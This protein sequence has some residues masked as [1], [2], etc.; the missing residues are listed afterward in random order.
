[1]LFNTSITTLF[2]CFILASCATK[3]TPT[4]WQ[5]A[6]GKPTEE[7]LLVMDVELTSAAGLLEQG[8]ECHLHARYHDGRDV[9]FA[10]KPGNRRSFWSAPAG[11]YEM[12][13]LSCGLFS[14]FNLPDYPAFTVKRGESYY[15]GM[16]KLHVASKDSLTW[17]FADL[18][19]DRLLTQFI[20]LPEAIKHRV[21]S[22][23][24]ERLI[25]EALIKKTPSGPS[26]RQLAPSS[27]QLSANDWPFTQCFAREQKINPLKAGLWAMKVSVE[28][29]VLIETLE[30]HHLYT[31]QF[32]DCVSQRL[33]DWKELKMAKTS[34]EIRL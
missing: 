14:R 17:S 19:R 24:S 21:L 15:F 31:K 5:M 29:D 8:H 9:K 23:F 7:G 10:L 28:G 11:Y 20:S 25:N 3:P 13:F 22:P 32:V 4:S 12:K 30:D 33:S 34:L 18:E 2:F 6:Q 26:V 16:L 27:L 1:M